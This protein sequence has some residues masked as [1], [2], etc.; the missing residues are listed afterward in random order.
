M[1]KELRSGIIRRLDLSDCRIQ[2]EISIVWKKDNLFEDSFKELF[3]DFIPNLLT[4]SS[5]FI[6]GFITFSSILII[7]QKNNT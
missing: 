3:E 4:N 6:I 5:H 1:L 2:H 7:V